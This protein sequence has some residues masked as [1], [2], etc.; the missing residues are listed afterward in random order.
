MLKQDNKINNG[1]INA[2]AMNEKCFDMF[3]EK[4][5]RS[6]ISH[7][8]NELNWKSSICTKCGKEF[9][10]LKGSTSCY[11]ESCS[12]IQINKAPRIQFRDIKEVSDE[13]TNFFESSGYYVSYPLCIVNRNE[14]WGNTSLIVS[15]VQRLVPYLINDAYI[16]PKVFIAQPSV[17]T[18]FRGLSEYDNWSTSSFIN[19]SILHANSDLDTHK[20]AISS[21][22]ECLD[23]VGVDLEK[24][25]LSQ[26]REST[27]WVGRRFTR[28]TLDFFYRGLHLSDAIYASD[29]PFGKAYKSFS[30]IGI[31]LERL[32]GILNGGDFYIAQVPSSFYEGYN[33][34]SWYDA[35]KALTLI[36]GSGAKSKDK[37]TWQS[38]KR[39]LNVLNENG[40]LQG[41]EQE[42]DVKFYH[43]YWQ[44]FVIDFS[45]TETI[46]KQILNT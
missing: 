18:Q 14:V 4:D 40:F 30:D 28:T 17:R 32:T 7:F 12:E 43:D 35:L 10:H 27:E 9:H 29:Y 25:T 38:V 42:N 31:G 34:P 22:L 21:W 2:K 6:S 33:N 46:Q 39:Y 15:G 13:I 1:I 45:D 26:R 36:I 41:Q 19:P 16:Q 37:D 23:T 20:Q 11:S 8:L 3:E 44:K 24:I 5:I